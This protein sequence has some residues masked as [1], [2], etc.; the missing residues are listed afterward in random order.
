ME[1]GTFETVRVS[2]IEEAHRALENGS[3]DAFVGGSVTVDFFSAD[4]VYT[5]DFFPL[6]FNPVSMATVKKELE[7]VISVV[8]KALTNG[9]FSYLSH[10]YN[11]GYLDYMKHKLFMQLSDAEHQYIASH[12]VVPVVANYDNFPVCFYNTREGKWQGIFFDLLDEITA[13]TG[14]SFNL[15]NENN[16]DWPIIY[17]M[18]KSG[19]ASLIADLTWTQERANYFCWPE[20]GP[21][22]DYLALVS[23]S[24]YRDIAISEIRNARVGVAE[25]TVY[26]STFKQWFPDHTNTVEYENMIKAIAALERGEVDMVMSSQRRLMFVTHYLELPGYKTNIVFDQALQTLFGMNKNEQALCSIIDKALNVIDTQGISERWMHRTYDYRVKVAE[27]RLPWLIGAIILSLVVLT[28]ILILFYRNRKERK[29]LIKVEAQVMAREADERTKIMFDSTPLS[30]TLIDKDYNI[31]DC[32]KE[33]E[34]FFGIS[35]KHEFTGRFFEFA[36]EYQSDGQKSRDKA[37]F[38]FK[39]TFEEGFATLDWMHLIKGELVPCEVTLVRVKYYDEYIIA[40]YARDLRKLKEAEAKAKEADERAQLMLEHTPLSVLLWDKNLQILDCNQEAV[41]ILGV[42][43]KKEYIERFFELAPEYQPN[44]MTSQEMAQKALSQILSKTGDDRFEWTMKH[45][46]TGEEIPFEIT[47]VRINYKG[48]AAVLSYAQD[49]RELKA[50]I[51]KIRE[52]DERTQLIL[53][54]APFACCMFDKDRNMIDCNQEVVK[55]FGIPDREFFLN[56]F[57][58]SLFP[59]YQS[60]GQLS[61]E[62][63][64]HNI[65]IALEKGYSRI[66]CMHQKLDG[67]PL[68]SE[69]TLVRV[70][71]RGINVIV[72]HFRDLTEQKAIVR[73]AKQQAEAEA[74]NRAK[75]SFLANMSHEMRTPMNAIVGL[76][77]LMLEED[78]VSANVKETLEKI[79]TA[80]TTLMGLINDVLDISK[81]ESGKQQLNPVQYEVASFLNDIISL[82]IIRIGDRNIAFK[83][84]ITEDLPRSLFGDDLRIKQILNNLLSN[85]FKYTEKGTVTLG[86][87]SE[88]VP[89]TVFVIF[90][91]SDTGIGIRKEDMHKLFD[92]YIQV[93]TRANREIEGTGLGL[94]IT[95]RLIEL[96]DGEITV[97][98]EYGKGTTFRVRIRQGYVTNESIGKETV[99]SLHNFRYS[100]KK[101]QAQAKLVRSDLS[102]AKVLVVDDFPTNL[103]VA[104]GML[105]KYLMQVDCVLSGQKAVDRI[106]AGDP[107][108]NAIFM[109]HMMPG[110]DGV[111]AVR[112]IRALGTEYAKKVPIIALTANAIDGSEQMFLDN[113]FNAFL[114]KPFNVMHLDSVV[115]K[116]VRDKTKE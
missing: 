20:S 112:K 7:P 55:M 94:S 9:A 65:N 31:L 33:A 59:E 98:S 104:A 103:D 22:P 49:L 99:E 41:R 43:S 60:D 57:F 28:L 62:V 42:S 16:A 4:N 110:M 115:Q 46:E 67:T 18:V 21:L 92:D 13:V 5:E 1:A 51:A 38:Y 66:E 95:K 111:E 12:P 56:N 80:G 27:A 79:S 87:R 36:P 30:S 83:L 71:Y 64:A 75:T 2:D 93:D 37:Y 17:E 35:S 107:V 101:K 52:T 76:T 109:D 73:L 26:A 84:D 102:Y 23:K 96:M 32:N 10:L 24:E 97:E 29:R 45:P 105:R 39:K 81:I 53:D 47:L 11:Q 113:G 63:V 6:I 74:A 70:K 116:W 3:I 90:T 8:N 89:D 50:S 91:I 85:A 58:V 72:G 78:D 114:P 68:P 77:D 25:G 14:L 100:D 108:Y 40:G 54:T 15:I 88:E 19:Q 69:I 82:N 86:I 106:A 48:E 34:R 44:G 61:V